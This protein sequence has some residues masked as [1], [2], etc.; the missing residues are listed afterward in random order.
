MRLPSV[1]C[2]G[3][4]VSIFPSFCHDFS[5]SSLSFNLTYACRAIA[6]QGRF[7]SKSI[8]QIDNPSSCFRKKGRLRKLSGYAYFRPEI[9]NAVE[10]C[11]PSHSLATVRFI[12]GEVEPATGLAIS[13]EEADNDWALRKTRSFRQK[14]FPFP[15]KDCTRTLFPYYQVAGMVISQC[16]A[17]SPYAQPCVS[18]YG[19]IYAVLLPQWPRVDDKV[20]LYLTA[21]PRESIQNRWRFGDSMFHP[22]YIESPVDPQRVRQQH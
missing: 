1:L 2:I 7:N 9:S 17:T 6:N 5:S 22:P 18:H 15:I 10:P 11:N 13:I 8:A 12:S 19:T 3:V 21:L 16:Y 20:G 4:A 14:R